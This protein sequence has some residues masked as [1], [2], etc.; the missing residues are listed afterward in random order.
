MNIKEIREM[1]TVVNNIHESCYRSY[2]ILEFVKEFLGRVRKL[3]TSGLSSLLLD[4]VE[5]LEDDS[6]QGGHS[7][8]IPN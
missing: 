6:N 3:D 2:F 1:P 4:L 5:G 7:H 8:G